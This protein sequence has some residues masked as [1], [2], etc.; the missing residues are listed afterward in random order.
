MSKP[1]LENKQLSKQQ[2]LKKENIKHKSN[3]LTI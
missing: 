2:Y 3:V 1:G